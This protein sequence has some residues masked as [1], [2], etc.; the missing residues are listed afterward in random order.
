[1]EENA[2]NCMFFSRSQYWIPDQL[3]FDAII[4]SNISRKG[5]R[6]RQPYDES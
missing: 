1:M 3:S 6:H 4:K 2:L 5:K